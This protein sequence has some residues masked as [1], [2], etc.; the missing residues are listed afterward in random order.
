MYFGPVYLHF[1]NREL[2]RSVCIENRLPFADILLKCAFFAAGRLITPLAAVIEGCTERTLEDMEVF[3]IFAC[4]DHLQFASDAACQE[5]FLY[6]RRELY[7]FDRDRYPA[8]FLRT[9]FPDWMSPGILTKTSATTV[10]EQACIL[11]L[12]ASVSGKGCLQVE[13][14][15]ASDRKRLIDIVKDRRDSALTMSLFEGQTT[16]QLARTMGRFLSEKYIEHYTSYLEAEIVTGIKGLQFFDQFS[17]AF[18][19]LDLPITEQILSA[20]LTKS[21]VVPSQERVSTTLATNIA[22][23]RETPAHFAMVRAF[24]AIIERV[25]GNEKKTLELRSPVAIRTAIN[26]AVSQA[27]MGFDWS[28]LSWGKDDQGLLFEI[29]QRFEKLLERIPINI[30]DFTN[31]TVSKYNY[32]YDNSKLLS[33][34]NM[35][36]CVFVSY[37]RDDAERVSYLC[38]RLRSDGLTV[39]QD[40]SD[41]QPGQRWK[42]AIRRAISNSAFAF[43]AC[44]SKSYE[45]RSVS[46]MNQELVFAI[47]EIM[48]RPHDR[49]WFIP[50]RLDE[51]VIPDRSIGGGETLCD[52]NQID[53]FPDFEKGYYT[54]INTLRNIS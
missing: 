19:L 35:A 16:P 27:A 33:E 11:T 52:I 53:L 54:L 24:Q 36:K 51:V 46:Y 13:K 48:K 50:V 41:L 10:L 4:S 40:K 2:L 29:T 39:W 9:S 30:H 42:L 38:A 44:F 14:I 1:L 22:A 34:N 25:V 23:I 43:L 49:T 32:N 15:S 3:G 12:D 45:E 20:T 31:Y 47:D 21:L 7:K 6:S 26:A 17:N 18:P 28:P 8:Y 5:D 37:V